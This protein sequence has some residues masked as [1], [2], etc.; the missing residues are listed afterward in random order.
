MEFFFSSR[1]RH[2]RCALVTGVQTCALPIC[3]SASALTAIAEC[4]ARGFLEREAGGSMAA[5]SAQ[6]FGLVVHAI[7]ERV[8]REE[9]SADPADVDQLMEH[10]DQVWDRLSFRT[11]WSGRR[12]REELS[13]A[14]V[15]FLN[16]HAASSRRLVGIEQELTD[17]VTLP[18][19]Q[20]VTLHG[21]ADRIEVD[22]E[23]NVVV[24]DLKTGKYKPTNPAVA[25]HPKL[26]VG[27]ASVRERGLQ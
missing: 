4:P 20:Q 21:F 6:G 26:D 23:G 16:W 19:G 2:T 7:A 3:L 1:R 8:A 11:P 15:C 25:V 9:L 13:L 27:R 17:Q 10:V 22:A 5:T 24:V 12:E 18:D 14:L